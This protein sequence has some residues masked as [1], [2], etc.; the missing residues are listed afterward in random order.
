MIEIISKILNLFFNIKLIW[1]QL[2]SNKS[3]HELKRYSMIKINT[4]LKENETSVGGMLLANGISFTTPF[5]DSSKIYYVDATYLGCTTLTWTGIKATIGP[6]SINDHFNEVQ[7]IFYPNPVND[8]LIIEINNL[9]EK[10]TLTF[11][12]IQGRVVKSVNLQPLPAKFSI[13]IDVKDLPQG[14]YLLNLKND[15]VFRTGRLVKYWELFHCW[16]SLLTNAY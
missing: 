2:F 7:V 10:A 3:Q 1:H 13:Q 16:P 15:S 6:N 14:L 4:L 8:V 5:L 9:N 12:D 11:I